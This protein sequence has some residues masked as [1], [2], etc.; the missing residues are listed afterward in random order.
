MKRV[1]IIII[2]ITIIV[3]IIIIKTSYT[4]QV[5]AAAA[6]VIAYTPGGGGGATLYTYASL[7]GGNRSVSLGARS[8]GCLTISSGALDAFCPR[9][10]AAAGQQQ[11]LPPIYT[12]IYIYIYITRVYIYIRTII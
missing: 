8:K 7:T 1:I 12:A 2:I 6:T 11:P 9:A 4:T 5:V 10:R 3:I